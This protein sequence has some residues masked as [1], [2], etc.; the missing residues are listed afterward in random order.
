MVVLAATGL[1]CGPLY[2]T[3]LAAAEHS[4]TASATQSF[5]YLVLALSFPIL[6]GWRLVGPATEG[7]ARR[8]HRTIPSYN[9]MEC[10]VVPYHP[11]ILCSAM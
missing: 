9:T 5:L 7:E 3:V 10:Y 4:A 8:H 6:E 2:L 1:L 11:I